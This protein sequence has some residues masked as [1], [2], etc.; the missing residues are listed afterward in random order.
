MLRYNP[1]LQKM[2]FFAPQAPF[3]E[4]ETTEAS[5]RCP[6]T[7]FLRDFRVMFWGHVL[8]VFANGICVLAVQNTTP[9]LL[10]IGPILSV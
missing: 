3:E 4:S 8:E 2:Y 1:D 5:R 7:G 6:L 10:E 9:E